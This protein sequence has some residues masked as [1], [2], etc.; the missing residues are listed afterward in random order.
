MAILTHLTYFVAVTG[1]ADCI[2]DELEAQTANGTLGRP[3]RVGVIP[4]SDTVWDGCECGQL[5]IYFQHGP[6]PV[7]SFP[8]ES[9]E[10][11]SSLGCQVS[12][13]AVRCVASLIRCEYH[14]PLQKNGEPPPIEH[15]TLATFYQQVEQFFMREAITCCLSSMRDDNLIDD[16]RVGA[17]DYL[18]NGDCGQVSIVFWL[19]VD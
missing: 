18:V 17:A 19:G 14:P 7:R 9:S 3:G 6:Y 15:Q 4:G 11:T 12:S 10:N 1:V 2:A 5:V 8:A 16:F 13:T